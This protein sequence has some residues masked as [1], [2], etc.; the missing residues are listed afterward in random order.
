MRLPRAFQRQLFPSY[1]T[2][3]PL[4][5][6]HVRVSGFFSLSIF[7]LVGG[8]WRLVV[9]LVFGFRLET[10]SGLSSVPVVCEGG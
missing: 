5:S 1:P 4:I 2:T 3:I 9:A 6:L 10:W 7:L 8:G